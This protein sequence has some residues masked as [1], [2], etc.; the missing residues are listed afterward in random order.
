MV[1]TKKVW[2]SIYFFI[3]CFVKL[4]EN[5]GRF[6]KCYGNASIWAKFCEI[7]SHSVR[8]S[9]YAFELYQTVDAIQMSTHN[10]CLYKENQ[11]KIALSPSNKSYSDFL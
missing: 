6:E 8:Y 5:S 1:K 7:L 3:S 2:F 10:I 4:V 11:K 9:M